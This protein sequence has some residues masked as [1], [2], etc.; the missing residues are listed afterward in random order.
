MTARPLTSAE[1]TELLTLFPV[2]VAKSVQD[3][4]R[5]FDSL[6]LFRQCRPD[7]VR[8]TIRVE[9]DDQPENGVLDSCFP[10]R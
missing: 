6:D 1:L 9:E 8:K 4:N 3:D 2:D 7:D 10:W 5:V